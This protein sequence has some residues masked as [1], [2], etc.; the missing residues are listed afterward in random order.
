MSWVPTNDPILGDPHSCDALELIIVP[1][2]WEVKQ[3]LCAS[4]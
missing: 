1:R 3:S 2:I 4:C